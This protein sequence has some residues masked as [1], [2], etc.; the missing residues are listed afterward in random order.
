MRRVV[1]VVGLLA[2]AVPVGKLLARLISRYTNPNPP[3]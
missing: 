2:A 1:T 3:G